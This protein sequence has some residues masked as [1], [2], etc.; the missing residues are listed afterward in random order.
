MRPFAGLAGL[1]VRQF[2]Q[3]T[4]GKSHLFRNAERHLSLL[5]FTFQL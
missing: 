5:S 2:R 4:G 1:P 3:L